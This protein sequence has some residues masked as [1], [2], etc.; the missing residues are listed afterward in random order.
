MPASPTRYGIVA[1]RFNRPI[2]QR[3]VDG[4]LG[5]FRSK[6]FPL[7]RVDLRWVPGSF[8]I[9]SAVL[10]MARGGRYRA[11]IGVGCILQG[12][13]PQFAVLSEAAT[14][15]L[16]IA[17]LLAGVP[18]TCGIVTAPSW[19]LA[20]KRSAQRGLNRGREAAESAW[21]MAALSTA[22]ERP[23]SRRARGPR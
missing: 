18:V 4:A 23:M 13:T 17:G 20:L 8:E 9:P 22:D 6:K 10:A 15:G 7:S 1:A 14:Q 12:E 11:L 16:L 5:F 19:D 3:L 2:T 21:E